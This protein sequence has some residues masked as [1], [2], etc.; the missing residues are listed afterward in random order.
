[1]V[2]IIPN[3]V[4]R[5]LCIHFNHIYDEFLDPTCIE[6][7]DIDSIIKE[8]LGYH[9]LSH[10]QEDSS[11][12]LV[13]VFVFPNYFGNDM[14]KK[15]LVDG[16]ESLVKVYAS[17]NLF[18]KIN[19]VGIK[20]SED[21][22]FPTLGEIVSFFL[23]TKMSAIMHGNIIPISNP[24]ENTN[25]ST[26]LTKNS[27]HKPTFSLIL[28]AFEG[29]GLAITLALA[30]STNYTNTPGN[31]SNSKSSNNPISNL[32]GSPRILSQS[33]K[34]SQALPPPLSSSLTTDS[35]SSSHSSSHHHQ[36][37][38]TTTTS[39]DHPLP[40]TIKM[41]LITTYRPGN[42]SF[43][44]IY[45]ELLTKYPQV[46]ILCLPL[47]PF[48][49]ESYHQLATAIKDSNIALDN[50][51]YSFAKDAY[52]KAIHPIHIHF[53]LKLFTAF[54]EM[55]IWN[56]WINHVF[57]TAENSVRPFPGNP[58]VNMDFVSNHMELTFAKY[59]KTIYPSN[60]KNNNN[61]NTDKNQNIAVISARTAMGSV[62][63]TL[64][65]VT[66]CQEVDRQRKEFYA[67]AL[68]QKTDQAY[69]RGLPKSMLIDSKEIG[70]LVAFLLMYPKEFHESILVADCGM[71]LHYHSLPSPTAEMNKKQFFSI[72]NDVWSQSQQR[73]FSGSDNS[74]GRKKNNDGKNSK[75]PSTIRS[76]SSNRNTTTTI[77]PPV[78]ITH[79]SI[80]LKT[81]LKYLPEYLSIDDFSSS[82][83]PFGGNDSFKD[84]LLENASAGL[85]GSTTAKRENIFVANSLQTA[86]FLLGCYYRKISF[87]F[88]SSSS[89]SSSTE[90]ET[91]QEIRNILSLD[92]SIELVQDGDSSRCHIYYATTSQM[93][94]KELQKQI[95]SL[96]VTGIPLFIVVYKSSQFFASL[97]S[98][99]STHHRHHQQ[100]HL[101]QPPEE[102]STKQLHISFLYEFTYLPDPSIKCGVIISHHEK[103]LLRSLSTNHSEN[104]ISFSLFTSYFSFSS[105]VQSYILHKLNHPLV[106]ENEHISSNETIIPTLEVRKGGENKEQIQQA[107][108]ISSTSELPSVWPYTL[109][110]S[111]QQFFLQY[112][113]VPSLPLENI[114]LFS[115][116][117]MA[118]F[119]LGT[120]LFPRQSSDETTEERPV[121]MMDS[122]FDHSFKTVFETHCRITIETVPFR[123]FSINGDGKPVITSRNSLLQRVKR[124][125]EDGYQG[126]LIM[127]PH[128]PTGH[129]YSRREID[130][131]CEWHCQLNQ[132]AATETE[133]TTKKQSFQLIFD[134]SLVHS[135]HD[136]SEDEEKSRF[137]SALPFLHYQGKSNACLHVLRGFS[138]SCGFDENN[139]NSIDFLITTNPLVLSAYQKY[140]LLLAPIPFQL[141]V[142]NHFYYH[143]FYGQKIYHEHQWYLW[144]H[145][146]KV[147]ILLEKESI[148]YIKPQSGFHFLISLHSV[149]VTCCAYYYNEFHLWK[150]LNEQSRVN[151][152][153]G[154]RE[155]PF[156]CLQC[157]SL[158]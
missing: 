58:E 34:P 33:Q 62:P 31:T 51:I 52:R 80:F 89:S 73:R 114:L 43:D 19:I 71:R 16:L 78:H 47:D 30:A 68:A 24:Q 65:I 126:Y 121:L 46:S 75:T 14:K 102:K 128:S 27:L 117:S 150:K 1:V 104:N 106:L 72:T 9:D 115:S 69:L 90:K 154:K 8:S 29:I 100:H 144:S 64:M 98:K 133:F 3:S 45:D 143:S 57:L 74:L 18:S 23:T 42:Y 85:N 94:A 25:N 2:E 61:T 70:N 120:A 148:V 110:G 15:L 113:H 12:P 135:I 56:N 153:P 44:H 20:Y 155:Y 109:Q 119:L 59:L 149:L 49:S 55:N 122:P 22:H 39:T 17:Q 131:L 107:M 40:P 53:Y 101:S 54:Q 112:Q 21:I 32:F 141:K 156:V 134:E 95:S 147:C 157:I 105:F 76:N 60:L 36:T 137:Q 28:D 86:I 41:H 145:A 81:S 6:H 13:L 66:G 138:K 111:L 99:D 146:K 123:S 118:L 103:E 10:F 136:P 35:T 139:N 97:L 26:I 82:S 125:W 96:H 50:I 142:M 130:E 84:Y 116:L 91:V 132:Q 158:H 77:L 151:L 63:N 38:T 37:T 92:P 140:Q 5:K 108:S 11:Q 93:T 127:N 87:T 88:P 48:H 129:I 79:N 83:T 7:I 67:E 152:I 124:A 4:V